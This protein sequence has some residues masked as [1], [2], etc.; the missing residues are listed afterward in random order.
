MTMAAGTGPARGVVRAGRRLCVQRVA[1]ASPAARPRTLTDGP[2]WPQ[3]FCDEACSITPRFDGFADADN[4]IF[5]SVEHAFGAD[6]GFRFIAD[7]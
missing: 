7:A 6:T 5:Q 3:G 2:V 1:G 4:V